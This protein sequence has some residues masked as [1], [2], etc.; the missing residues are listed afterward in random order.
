MTEPRITSLLYQIL[1]ASGLKAQEGH[2]L[3]VYRI[4]PEESWSR[5]ERHF[6]ECSNGD[7]R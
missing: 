3:Y 4:S 6:A 1:E 2:P 7:W 5:C